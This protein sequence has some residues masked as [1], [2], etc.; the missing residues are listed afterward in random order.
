MMSGSSASTSGASGAGPSSSANRFRFGLVSATA[1]TFFSF[2]SA[3]FSRN[4]GN[5]GIDSF[6]MVGRGIDGTVT[7][8]GV[9]P[10]AFSRALRKPASTFAG[11]CRNTSSAISNSPTTV[12]TS[13]ANLVPATPK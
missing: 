13:S 4:R 12:A 5:V 3:N 7:T 9:L 10:S 8:T 11:Q 1:T 6:G 2:F